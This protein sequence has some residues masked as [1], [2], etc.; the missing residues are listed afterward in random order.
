MNDT[1]VCYNQVRQKSS[2]NSYQ[3]KEGLPGQALYWRIRSQEI[4]IHNSN[5]SSGWPQLNSDWY[6]YH[7]AVVDQGTS[8]NTLK[9]ALM[10]LKS[11]QEAVPEHE[12]MTIWLDLKDDFI[13]ERNQTPES[14]DQLII[15]YLGRDNIWGPPDLIGSSANLQSAIAEDQW[16]TLKNL[17]GKFIFGCTTGDLSSPSSVLNQYVENGVT[18]NQRLCFVAPQISKSNDITSHDYAVIFNLSS[19]NTKLAQEV[20]DAGFVSRVYGLNSKDSWSTAWSS[21]ANH[22]GTDKVNTEEDEWARTDLADTGYPFTGV[23]IV[24]PND[25]TEP[26][27]LYAIKVDSEDIWKREDSFY[28]QYDDFNTN[29]GRELTAFIANPQSHVDSWIKGGIMA[30]NGIADD[31]AYVAV[32]QTGDEKI[33]VQFRENN[34][35]STSKI[36]ANIPDGVNGHSQ[37]G[38]NTPI[39][40]KLQIDNDG[41]KVTS[42]YSINGS[43]WIEIAQVAVKVPLNLQGL[44]AAS[45]GDGE[46]KWLFGGMEAPGKGQAIGSRASGEF[47]LDSAEAA[48]LGPYQSNFK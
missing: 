29:P 48:S 34:G 15:D 18:A 35:D 44:A 9:D 47:I 8:V 11:F 40:F 19:G 39:W 20:F 26:G 25:L 10:V 28:F 4:D 24:L 45:H 16:P 5:N 38:N 42:S 14:L 12:V 17:Q 6:V 7:A 1:Q 23:D 3:R 43:D 37:V 2:H 32:F 13:P 33:R 41:K 31:S 27:Q 46:T 22:L 30:R 21:C 36:D